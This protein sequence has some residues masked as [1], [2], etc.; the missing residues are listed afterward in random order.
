MSE[1]G[2]ILSAF[3]EKNPDVPTYVMHGEKVPMFAVL[4]AEWNCEAII[5]CKQS[6]IDKIEK[7]FL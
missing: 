6:F 1:I 4:D 3:V 2:K 7:E 5:L